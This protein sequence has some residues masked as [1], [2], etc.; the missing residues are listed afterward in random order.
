MD[1]L[2]RLAK[3]LMLH[4]KIERDDFEKLM[5]GEMPAEMFEEPKAE[6]AA[7]SDEVQVEPTDVPKVIAPDADPIQSDMP[8]T[9]PADSDQP[10]A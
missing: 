4:E 6:D 9:P 7:E 10:Q 8:D 2:E 3:Y 1:Q 5:R